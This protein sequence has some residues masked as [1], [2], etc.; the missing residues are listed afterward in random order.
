MP[1]D[2]SFLHPMVQG[3]ISGLN[4]QQ[5]QE[6]FLKET[7]LKQKE[8]EFNAQKT[9][10]ALEEL[11]NY[12][13]QQLDISGKT[14]KALAGLRHSQ[15]MRMIQEMVA[16]GTNANLIGT[17]SQTQP[18]MREFDDEV[19]DP[20]MWATPEQRGQALATQKEQMLP[21]EYGS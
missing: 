16:S 5:D 3:L 1:V 9:K 13:T 2:I 10:E 11:H 20:K 17:P 12:H 21:Y 14:Q 15:T 18:G 8:L 4:R 7:E 6:Q 19:F